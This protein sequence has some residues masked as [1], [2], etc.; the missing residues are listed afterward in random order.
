MLAVGKL[1]RESDESTVTAWCP[2]HRCHG[3]GVSHGEGRQGDGRVGVRCLRSR[4][5]VLAV[6]GTVR[7]VVATDTVSATEKVARETDEAASDVFGHGLV[8]SRFPGQYGASLPR[9]RCQPRRRS[10]GRRT[11]RRQM[12]S[13]TAWCP[14]GSRDSPERRCHGHGVS[15]GEGR[16]G[17][18]RG[19][20]RCLRSRPG[21][22][23][24]PGTERSVVATDTVSATE[25]VARETDEAASDVFGHGLVSSRFPGQ[26]GASLP[27]TRCQPRRRSPG[28]WTRRRQMSSV[29]AWCPPD[30]RSTE[31]RCQVN[32]TE[33][34]PGRRGTEFGL[35]LY[36]WMFHQRQ[37]R[38]MECVVASQ[39]GPL[40]G[41]LDLL[42][43][44]NETV[45]QT[46]PEQAI[47]SFGVLFAQMAE[48]VRSRWQM[49]SLL[50]EST[51]AVE[52]NL[53][54]TFG[55]V[56]PWHLLND[57]DVNGFVAGAATTVEIICK[58]LLQPPSW[59]ICRM[60]LN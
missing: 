51:R 33:T 3:H 43:A 41:G 14:R 27:R 31:R 4:P 6:P 55:P 15:H 20:V 48:E 12:S 39:T 5:G 28:R 23:A 53:P 47:A 13:V 17:N 26:Y 59:G 34:G 45:S 36:R 49:P 30:S 2:T 11:R 46:T 52:Y 10:P 40:Q 60:T 56:I 57:L 35:L 18:G 42:L 8:S 32:I 22:L 21:V 44:Q 38:A 37:K 7:S 9:T 50:V 24:V 54:D 58:T 16:Q 19:G 29:T 25:K 1:A